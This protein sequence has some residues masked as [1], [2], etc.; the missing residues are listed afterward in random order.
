MRRAL[1]LVSLA[2]LA[3]VVAAPG[4]AR[5]RGDPIAP[6]QG[7]AVEGVRV[8]VYDQGDASTVEISTKLSPIGAQRATCTVDW[9]R[10][11]LASPGGAAAT[12]TIA[13][14]ETFVD[15]AL[16]Q[17]L[18][19]ADGLS[20]AIVPA[21]KGDVEAAKVVALRL[22]VE[23]TN[24]G[25]RVD[26]P[27]DTFPRATAPGARAERRAKAA[28]AA[29][30]K[31]GALGELAIEATAPGPSNAFGPTDALS[32]APIVIESVPTGAPVTQ[33]LPSPI[34]VLDMM[35][36]TIPLRVL[37]LSPDNDAGWDE[38]ARYAYAASLNG[39]P[40][41]ASLGVHTLAWLASGLSLEAVGVAAASTS[42]DTA[43][44]PASIAN[45]V[46]DP[47]AR[48]AKTL[49]G[50][51]RFLPLGRPSTFK[52]SLAKRPE[53]DA[54]RAKAA[55]DAIARLDGAK[56]EDLAKF[57]VPALLDRTAPVDPPAPIPTAAPAPI[58][59]RE[60]EPPPAPTPDVDHARVARR[61]R[62]VH[63]RPPIGAL[64][65]VLAAGAAI[66]LALLD[67]RT[68]AKEA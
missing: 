34:A 51:G 49:G 64:F 16:A 41:V 14:A 9:S 48:L 50:I 55:R 4:S 33:P 6:K 44:V 58:A 46:G 31:F 36:T 22:V 25:L 18:M 24:A 57:A 45:A 56:P 62:H 23:G 65:G 17:P 54:A 28:R 37:D 38:T 1:A 29:V 20:S 40:V 27:R 30:A 35:R 66:A 7:C 60:V 63:R 43:V 39:D 5:G 21:W 8:L 32:E 3:V 11:A 12:P 2:A 59:P 19:L 53:L 42:P 67:G 47:D 26:V 61:A 15:H 52:K 68:R 13:M 10:V